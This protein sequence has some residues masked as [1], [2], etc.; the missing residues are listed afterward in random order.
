MQ[1]AQ[2]LVIAAHSP[3]STKDVATTDVRG[4]T[5]NDHGVL[6][7]PTMIVIRN[8]ATVQVC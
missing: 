6:Q 5:I 8:G 1:D 2:L 3:S 7:H 4:E